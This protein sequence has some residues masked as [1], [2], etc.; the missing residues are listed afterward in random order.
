MYYLSI[1]VFGD[2]KIKGPTY[3]NAHSL[4]HVVYLEYFEH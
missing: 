1:R 4:F 3:Y 2:T